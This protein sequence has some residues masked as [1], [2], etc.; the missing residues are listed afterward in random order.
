MVAVEHGINQTIVAIED[1]NRRDRVRRI[2]VRA[3]VLVG[4]LGVDGIYKMVRRLVPIAEIQGNPLC[5]MLDLGKDR[6]GQMNGSG[7]RQ[8]VLAARGVD[9]KAA[10][11]DDSETN[12]KD[13]RRR[14]MTK[15]TRR[16]V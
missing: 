14:Q 13:E 10:D 5:P 9:D 15:Q 11:H 12:D 3:D 6:P 16:P 2:D 1:I 8:F 7:G 4:P